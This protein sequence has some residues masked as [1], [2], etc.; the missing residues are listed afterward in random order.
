MS[1][2]LITSENMILWNIHFRAVIGVGFWKDTYTKEIHGLSGFQYT[3]I[4]PFC[5]LTFSNIYTP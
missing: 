3:V 5:S 4:L 2:K 1:D